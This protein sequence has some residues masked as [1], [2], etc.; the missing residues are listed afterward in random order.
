MIY[1]SS[2]YLR[3]PESQD[4]TMYHF[5]GLHFCVFVLSIYM[6]K[7][8]LWNKAGWFFMLGY[9]RIPIVETWYNFKLYASHFCGDES[10]KFRPC[11]IHHAGQLLGWGFH[12]LSSKGSTGFIT[13]FFIAAISAVYS[14][15]Y[16]E[17]KWI[18][19]FK[20]V[21]TY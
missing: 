13:N 6:S 8:L 12:L 14:F 4:R 16:C 7:D 18:Y 21:L 2:R 3:S 19:Y 10:N 1:T 9:H 15:E 20:P 17:L 5:K 11:T